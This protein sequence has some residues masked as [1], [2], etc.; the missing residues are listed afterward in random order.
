MKSITNLGLKTSL[1]AAALCA[2][3]SFANAQVPPVAP[4]DL[5]HAPENVLS[6]FSEQYGMTFETTMT[7]PNW[8]QSA[9]WDYT[10]S[11]DEKLAIAINN[12]GDKG[13]LPITL[14]GTADL[15]N[16]YYVHIDVFCN[17]ATNFRIGFQRHYPDN[18]E[19]YFPMI[20]KDSMKAGKWY[21]IDYS[22]DEFFES[23]YGTGPQ[24]V[25]HYLRFGG[26]SQLGD[27]VPTWSNE[28][29][30]ANFVL[31]GEGCTPTALGGKVIE[32]T[33]YGNGGNGNDDNGND[34]NGNDDNGNNDD[35][36]DTGNND[37]D[38]DDNT[39]QEETGINS[40]KDE[41]GFSAYVAGNELR[42]S[43]KEAIRSI[44]VYSLAGQTVKIFE[45]NGLASKADVSGL[46]S[47]VYIVSAELANGRKANIKVIKQ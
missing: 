42:Y 26:E 17:E 41:S 38:D 5:P 33:D 1:S 24:C 12:L 30:I 2:S 45:V 14:G 7:S 15:R 16:Y 9:T 23:G 46:A 13:W 22:L 18:L 34:D 36:D 47:G 11:A 6:F 25:T 10:A 27:Y 32:D 40:P 19:H 29:Y 8:G 39:G 35:D 44:H 28:I 43:A 20:K 4:P 37:D 31:L 3:I 21:S